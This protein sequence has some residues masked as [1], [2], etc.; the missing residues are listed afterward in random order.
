MRSTSSANIKLEMGL[1]PLEIEVWW[2]WSLLHF[3]L[4]EKVEQDGRE[5]TSLTDAH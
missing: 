5:Q 4:K 3:L 1:P 2:P